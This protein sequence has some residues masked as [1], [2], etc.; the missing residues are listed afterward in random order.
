MDT[1]PGHN[2]AGDQDIRM[3]HH[4]FRCDNDRCSGEHRQRHRGCSGALCPVSVI[5]AP[6]QSA[7][8]RSRRCRSDILIDRRPDDVR[9][10][11]HNGDGGHPK[12][13]LALA[14]QRSG[15]RSG[16]C[17]CGR[18][19]ELYRGQDGHSEREGESLSG[20]RSK[21]L[22]PLY[23]HI[24]IRGDHRGALDN[25]D[26]EPPGI[27]RPVDGRCGRDNIRAYRAIHGHQGRQG[28]HGHD[29]VQGGHGGPGEGRGNPERAQARRLD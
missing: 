3:V 4:L 17:G 11:R 29:N 27:Q 12:H 20:P 2:S 28:I 23:G 18:S 8:L 10:R 15:Y 24:H 5:Q 19:C 26:S 1:D 13:H 22:S 16:T 6:G 7:S 25:T 9:R 14:P 21:R